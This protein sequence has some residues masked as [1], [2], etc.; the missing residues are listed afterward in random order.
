MRTM[1]TIIGVIAAIALIGGVFWYFLYGESTPTPI[2]SL[3][4][5]GFEAYDSEDIHFEYP[6]SYA[7][8]ER[9]DNFEGNPI[10]V[11]TLVDKNIVVPDMSEGPPSI[12][13]IVVRNSADLPLD[14]WIKEKSI[15][16]FALSTD[17]R[18][19]SSTL[20][21]K[22]AISYTHSGLYESTAI[23]TKHKD[24][25]FLFSVGSINPN[26]EI[27]S[28]FQELLNTVHFK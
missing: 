14:R 17:Q 6:N 20:D 1:L 19:A 25:I 15:S 18:L 5:A 11:V 24:E 9:A 21:A 7:L 16:N 8:T 4:P 23:A 3:P 13:L 2:T 10:V 28:D 12:S 27:Y 26:D 22:Q